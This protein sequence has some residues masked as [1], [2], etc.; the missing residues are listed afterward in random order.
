MGVVGGG[1]RD[2]HEE[3][4][5][6]WLVAVCEVVKQVV[7]M[8]MVWGISDRWYGAIGEWGG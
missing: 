7:V 4:E 8:V 2:L 5:Q 1:W 3:A 6:V